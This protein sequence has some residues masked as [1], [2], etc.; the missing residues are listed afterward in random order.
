MLSDGPHPDPLNPESGA[1]TA[2]TIVRYVHRGVAY[3]KD[4]L[5]DGG[6]R[7]VKHVFR[8]DLSPLFARL[9]DAVKQVPVLDGARDAWCCTSAGSIGSTSRPAAAWLSRR[10]APDLTSA[11]IS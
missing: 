4:A 10:R 6:V 7:R 11:P 1:T 3:A 9:D 2:S 5:R 8:Y